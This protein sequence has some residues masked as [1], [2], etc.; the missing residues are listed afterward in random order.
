MATF[1]AVD[2][3]PFAPQG[4]VTRA[5][6]PEGITRVTVGGSQKFEPVDYDP[7]TSAASDVAKSAG[8]GLVKG[9][10]GLAALPGDAASLAKAGADYAL[11]GALENIG[12]A[13]LPSKEKIAQAAKMIGIPVDQLSAAFDMLPRGVKGAINPLKTS[14]DIQSG[15][16][17]VTGEFYKPKTMA[18]EYAQTIGEFAPA[19][20]GSPGGLVAKAAGVLVPAIASETA[21]QLTKGTK[22]EPYARFGGALVGGIGT[23]LASRPGNASKALRGQLPEGVT[24]QMVDQAEVLMQDAAR[25]GVDIAW[26]EAL[27]QVAGR[28]VLTNMM[29][30]LEASPQTEGRMAEFFGQRPQQVE[31]SVRG[32]ME[33]IA[34]VNQNPSTIGRQVG[35]AA[36]DEANF[37]R[38]AINDASQPYYDQASTVRLTNSEM[39]QVQRIPGYQE[40]RDAVRNDPQLNRYVAHLPDDSV[41]FL[42]EVK[43]Y[44]DTAAENAAAP[45]NQQR[46]MQRSAGYG[47]D[48]E[49]SRAIALQADNQRG[50]RDYQIALELQRRGREEILQP[51]L[52][53]YIGRLAKKDLT[54]QKAIDTLF[55][56]RP[57]ANSEQEIGQAVGT[58][59]N[60][61]PR[62]AGDLVRAYVE[63]TF[64]ATA[65]ALQSGPNQA[66]GAKFR[67][68]LMG[69]QQQAANLQAAV[70]ALPNGAQRW[71]GFNRLM[72]VLEA[73]GT[74]QNVGSRT[75]YNA[76]INKAQSMGGLTRD[77]AKVGLNPLK[78]LAPVIER[79][80][81]WKL[82]RNLD[83]LARILTDPA[84]A[85]R[86]R[87]ISRMPIESDI[88]RN[89][90]IKL[91]TYGESSERS[92]RSPVNERRN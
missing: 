24:P 79:Y 27:S 33:N 63:Q 47:Q 31:R 41:G 75:A 77:A 59:A 85:N 10:I 70:T 68:A 6:A 2:Y 11:P 56:A 42:N 44:F 58:L 14:Q 20:L 9:A 17:G 7:F 50:N 83:E 91:L 72:D 74:R 13:A 32:E 51:L 34:P 52:D 60:R 64:H 55:P 90:A 22:A 65:K 5:V 38:G 45:I 15:I 4:G 78:A 25:R 66:G 87:A 3:D 35:Q 21:G 8:I 86:L 19:A 76:E 37:V 29:R 26:P 46:N 81:N 53:G 12:N 67:A 80:E 61:N 57:L 71:E 43:K 23:A 30:H 69:D 18:G 92:S 49:R 62:A 36:E 89:T 39:A 16:E 54:T 40:A 82:G 28:P 73:T 84:S 88:A 48:A 1:E